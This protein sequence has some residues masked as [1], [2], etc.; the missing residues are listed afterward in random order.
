MAMVSVAIAPDPPSEF[1]GGRSALSREVGAESAGYCFV[2]E[3]G[4]DAWCGEIPVP[5]QWVFESCDS[6]A[7]ADTASDGDPAGRS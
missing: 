4:A 5:V 2:D 3:D 7:D 6:D 1:L